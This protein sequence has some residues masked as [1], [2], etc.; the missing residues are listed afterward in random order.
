MLALLHLLTRESIELYFPL[1]IFLISEQKPKGFEL[2]SHILSYCSTITRPMAA[3]LCLLQGS[4]K[5]LSYDRVT[6]HVDLLSNSFHKVQQNHIR[7]QALPNCS[8]LRIVLLN[9]R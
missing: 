2:V 1:R 8:V 3:A 4:P 6:Y 9:R 5:A 7:D